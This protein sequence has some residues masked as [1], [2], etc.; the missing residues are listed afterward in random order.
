MKSIE[1]KI[2]SQGQVSVPARL[3]RKVGLTPGSIVEWCERGDE[4]V[5]RRASKYS[6]LDIHEAVFGAPPAR[7]SVED[8]DEGIRYHLRRPHARG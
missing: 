1:S 4:A 6:S 8:M 7:R 2:T 5:V 3:R